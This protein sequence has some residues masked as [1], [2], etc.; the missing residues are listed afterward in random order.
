MCIYVIRDSY[1]VNSADTP[2]GDPSYRVYVSFVAVSWVG[3][4][5]TYVVSVVFL[6]FDALWW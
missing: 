4:V 1:G 2:G 5:M 3:T 6:E